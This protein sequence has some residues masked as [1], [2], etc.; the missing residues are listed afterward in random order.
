MKILKT[1]YYHIN[2]EPTKETTSS[3]TYQNYVK[4]DV[5]YDKGGYSY[6]SYKQTPRAYFMSVHKVGRWKFKDDQYPGYMESTALFNNDGCKR[7]LF[8]VEKQSKKRSAEA[9]AYFDEHIDEFLKS[10]YPDLVLEKE[11]A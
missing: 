7:L 6:F 1:I 11:T 8:E 10:V 5:Y 4:A 2:G 9:E 3:E